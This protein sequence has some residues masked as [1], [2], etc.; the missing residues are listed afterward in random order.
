MKNKNHV[1]NNTP[2][3]PELDIIDLDLMNPESIEE[4]RTEDISFEDSSIEKDSFEDDSLEDDSL[5]ADSPKRRFPS[6][7]IHIGFALIICI[8]LG[9]VFWRV[10]NFGT[11]KNL[12]DYES[13]FSLEVLDSIMPLIP[14]EGVTVTD[15]GKTTIVAF[16]NAPFADDRDSKD[17]LANI[18]EDMTGATVINCSVG[19]S[20]LAADGATLSADIAPMD[21]FNF[22][23]LTT[24]FCLRNNDFVYQD[25]FH[26]LGDNMPEDGLEA[27]ETLMD[28]DFNTVDVIVLMYDGNDYLAGHN[29][30][31]DQNDTDIQ[32]F[33][34]NMCAGIDLI[35]ETYPH[36]RIIVMSPTYAFAINEEGEYVSSDKYRYGQD[37]LSTYVIKQFGYA[38]DRSVTFVDN[39]YGTIHED[40]AAQYLT[41]HLHLNVEGRKLVAERFVYALNYFD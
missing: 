8:I 18:I 12:S 14:Q 29:M 21:A 40:N 35:K 38:Y 28:I 17:S 3:I 16:G 41:D 36:I 1:N 39:L 31:S 24:A 19:S 27:Y 22:Y 7:L 13:E 30:Y 32:Q 25:I 2:N 26:T 33:T 10:L 20:Y 9:L 11:K 6:A 5:E 34:G 37:V 4:D 23:W 15:D